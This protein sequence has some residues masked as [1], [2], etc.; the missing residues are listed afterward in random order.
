VPTREPENRAGP[1]VHKE[2][3]AFLLAWVVAAGCIFIGLGSPALMDP[4]EGRNTEVAREMKD[5]RSFLVPIYNGMPYLDKPAFYFDAVAASMAMFG[6]NETA[7]RLPSAFFGALTLVV[8]WL[9][10]RHVYGKRAASMAVVI[11]GTTPLFIGFSRIV[12][13]DMALTFF[14]CS[15]VLAGFVALEKRDQPRAGRWHALTV[16]AAALATLVKGPV[17]FLL[18][19]LGLVVYSRV[20]GVKGGRRFFSPLHLLVFFVPVLVWFAALAWQ[21]PDFPYYG[22][23]KES[24]TRFASSAEFRRGA[25]VYY[26]IPLIA[27]VF[28]PWSLL[29]PEMILRSLQRRKGAARP[30][31]LLATFP[32]V[33]V[34]FFSISSSKLPGYVLPGV[35]ALGML[36]ARVFDLATA[37]PAGAAARL[38]RRG[39]VLLTIVSG[40]VGLVLAAHQL[41]L[42]SLQAAFHIRAKDLERADVWLQPLL[43]ALLVIAAGALAARASRSIPA[44]LG[45]FVLP[46]LLVLAVGGRQVSVYAEARSSRPLARAI[47]EQGAAS[48]EVAG[49]RCFAPGLPFYLR[50][51]M[52]VITEDGHEIPSNYILFTLKKPSKWPEQVVHLEDAEVW[53][54]SRTKPVLMLSRGRSPDARAKELA[55]ASG[56]VFRELTPRW[57]GALIPAQERN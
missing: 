52:T 35:V 30:D 36:T 13:F 21:R 53:I 42:L 40:A 26:Y 15:A 41:G 22:L 37:N 23:V 11:I 17:G 29:L 32:V 45:A 20:A 46:S 49:F 48:G 55:A 28:F 50:Q 4:D 9:F 39:S 3:A 14:V 56:A 18:P 1:A 19:L 33:V 8:V 24:L 12:I 47:Q 51:T 5:A 31:L 10:C 6:E 25:P 57:W 16:L 2:S 27:G 44:M 43:I 7:A 34:V 54:G 38:I